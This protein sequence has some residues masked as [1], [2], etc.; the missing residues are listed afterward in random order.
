MAKKSKTQTGAAAAAASKSVVLP[1]FREK[2]PSSSQ[3]SLTMPLARARKLAGDLYEAAGLAMWADA[4]ESVSES[5]KNALIHLQDSICDAAD[6]LRQA[7]AT[8]PKHLQLFWVA[9]MDDQGLPC[10]VPRFVTAMN[11]EEALQIWR[12]AFQ[13]AVKGENGRCTPH[14]WPA[15]ALAPTPRLHD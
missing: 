10:T 8:N 4:I 14:A 6:F 7:K 3:L 13:D 12:D 5:R 11:E 1:A 9:C 15:P 2:K